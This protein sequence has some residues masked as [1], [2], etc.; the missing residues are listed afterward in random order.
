ME[1]WFHFQAKLGQQKHCSHRA[2]VDIPFAKIGVDKWFGKWASEWLLTVTTVL[3]RELHL[4]FPV[5]WRNL[6]LP[7][8]LQLQEPTL[9]DW[10]EALPCT[11][12]GS[13]SGML[14]MK[15]SKQ[16][17]VPASYSTDLGWYGCR[18]DNNNGMNIYSTHT[19]I[20][21]YIL[22]YRHTH[23]DKTYVSIQPPY[24]HIIYGFPGFW[25]IIHAGICLHYF[26]DDWWYFDQEHGSG[27]SC[28][29]FELCK[30]HKDG[31]LVCIVV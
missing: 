25:L 31:R 28:L 6:K 16:V 10:L 26:G 30:A 2:K 20:Y 19:L 11:Q 24:M 3:A 27:V 18:Q 8:S 9:W 13:K 12:A 21:I 29:R 14:N 7:K 5:F 22:I 23:S 17:T 1:R 4:H 15:T